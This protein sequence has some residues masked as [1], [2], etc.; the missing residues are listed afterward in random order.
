M[1]DNQWS[2]LVESNER[3]SKCESHILLKKNVQMI[4]KKIDGDS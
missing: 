1:T 2:L 3:I 4:L